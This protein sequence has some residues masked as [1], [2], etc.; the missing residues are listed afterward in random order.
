MFQDPVCTGPKLASDFPKIG[1]ALACALDLLPLLTVAVLVGLT[2]TGLKLPPEVAEEDK[3]RPMLSVG[4]TSTI[5]SAAGN[6][7]SDPRSFVV[8]CVCSS[9][10]RALF[11]LPFL[12]HD[13]R[14]HSI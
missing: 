8:G 3:E 7:A 6:T 12:Q 5:S 11:V 14:E 2:S 10:L 1:F 9:D 4:Q 13:L